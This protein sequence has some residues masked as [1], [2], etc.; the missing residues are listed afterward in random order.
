VPLQDD[1]YIV[2]HTA[3]EYLSAARYIEKSRVL[4]LSDREPVYID[5]VLALT[6]SGFGVYTAMMHGASADTEMAQCGRWYGNEVE[7]VKQI[8][9]G[10]TGIHAAFAAAKPRCIWCV[11]KYG[12]DRYGRIFSSPDGG[13]L[14]I[15]AM[16][17]TQ[18]G[19][20]G[21]AQILFSEKGYN[22]H[23]LDEGEE[24]HETQ[25]CQSMAVFL[26]DLLMRRTISTQM[27][28]KLAGV[29]R[30]QI[31]KDG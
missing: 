12:F 2:S 20:A 18:P 11:T 23:V 17:L 1:E 22:V 8:P 6:E 7:I 5:P 14:G 25:Y 4:F 9:E 29:P 21:T 3:G 28:E 26:T 10:Y 16:G 31:V 24:L 30:E 13:Y 27:A 19:K 15:C